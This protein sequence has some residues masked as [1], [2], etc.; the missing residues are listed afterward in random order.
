MMDKMRSKIW[1][2][3]AVMMATVAVVVGIS[4]CYA[5]AGYGGVL[6]YQDPPPARVV[7]RPYAPGPGYAWVDGYWNW[8]GSGWVWADGHWTAPRPGYIVVQPRWVRQGRGWSYAP[9]GWRRGGGTVQVRPGAQVR[10]GVQVQPRGRGTV[11][12]NPPR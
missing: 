7:V 8:N 9:G 10:P 1:T 2:R 6:V 5:R 3:A 4:G 11:R 12:V